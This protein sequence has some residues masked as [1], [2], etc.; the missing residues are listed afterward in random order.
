MLKANEKYNVAKML[1]G[2]CKIHV[3]ESEKLL[4]P[5]KSQMCIEFNDICYSVRHKGKL[6][7]FLHI[8]ENC[9]SFAFSIS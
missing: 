2:D 7:S 3:Q 8:Y 1:D 4:G 9:D 6:I 5:E